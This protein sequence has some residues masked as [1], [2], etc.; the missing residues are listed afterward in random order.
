VAEVVA[1][2]PF[3]PLP[4]LGAGVAEQVGGLFLQLVAEDVL[5]AAAL[6]VQHRP[7]PQ[8]EV[9]RIVEPRHV[10]RTAPHQQRVAQ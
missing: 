2:Q 10:R 7:H 5:V 3:H 6:Q 9:L 8:Q 4:R 1:H